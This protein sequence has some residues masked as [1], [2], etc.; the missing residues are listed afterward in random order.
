VTPEVW[1]VVL[2][3]VYDVLTLGLLACV[4]W[5]TFASVWRSNVSL[6]IR[7]HLKDT[8]RSTSSRPGFNL[9][10]APTELE[11][12]ENLRFLGHFRIVGH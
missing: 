4:V 10:V 7:P 1:S 2:T 9:A 12:R 3:A 5:R 6:H 11:Q 8:K